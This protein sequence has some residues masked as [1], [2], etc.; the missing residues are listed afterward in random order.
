MTRLLPFLLA[1]FALLALGSESRAQFFGEG[2]MNDPFFQYYGFYLPRQAAM[3]AQPRAQDSIN[4]IAAARQYTAMT[5]R[6]S[7]YDP[8]QPFGAYDPNALFGGR[9]ASRSSGLASNGSNINGAGPGG[10]YNRTH[11]YFPGLRSGRGAAASAPAYT[12]R[13][14]RVGNPGIGSMTGVSNIMPNAR[15]R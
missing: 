8:I 15:G 11:T 7:L 12:P 1:T 14:G 5:E 4:A 10:Y 3:A 9:S 2:N 6:A 13:R